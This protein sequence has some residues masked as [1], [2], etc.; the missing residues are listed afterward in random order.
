MKTS[1]V[2]I[3]KAKAKKMLSYLCILKLT[4]LV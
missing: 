4:V 1:V 3:E 2:K